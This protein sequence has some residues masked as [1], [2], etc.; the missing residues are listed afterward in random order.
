M[1]RW[2]AKCQ[3]Q[4]TAVPNNFRTPTRM[5]WWSKPTAGSVIHNWVLPGIADKS[6]GY[7]KQTFINHLFS[8]DLPP[9]PPPPPPPI[10]HI[11]IFLS[12][13]HWV[14][15]VW[16]FSCKLDTKEGL[17]RGS[18]GEVEWQ[19]EWLI[20]WRTE[21]LVCQLSKMS[22][23]HLIFSD[24]LKFGWTHHLFYLCQTSHQLITAFNQN[25]S[26]TTNF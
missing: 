24:T 5:M 7:Q 1:L 8:S 4:M 13:F 19:E 16:T 11:L 21:K 12:K 15:H 23:C 22:S 25:I 9:P 6:S 10:F 18:P 3:S 17:G 2:D 14:W 20:W 26:L